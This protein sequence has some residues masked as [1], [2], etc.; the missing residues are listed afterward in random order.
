MY[1]MRE[2]LDFYSHSQVTFGQMT[3]LLGHY[4]SPDVVISCRMTSCYCKL[5]LLGKNIQ[6]TR[7]FG[8]SQ[9]LP[10]DYRTNNVTSG[11]L[12]VT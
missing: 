8:L 12:P 1:S 2:F 3:S 7:V 9:P 11:S 10:N 6:L 4:R 5:H